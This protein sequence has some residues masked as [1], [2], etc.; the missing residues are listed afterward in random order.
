MT[1]ANGMKCLVVLAI[2]LFLLTFPLRS[3]ACSLAGCSGDGE[4]MGRDFVVLVT[5]QGRPLP[6][7]S[8]WVTRFP[9][10]D[11]KLFLGATGTDGTTRITHAL[12]GEYWLH[13]DL[14]G[15]GAGGGCFHVSSRPSKKARQIVSYAWGDLAPATN[16][17]AGR[18]IDPQPGEGA[19]LLRNVLNHVVEPISGARLKLQNALTAEVYTTISN[20]DGGFSFGSIPNGTYV[21]HVEGGM[22]PG[23]RGYNPT[24]LLI[25]VSD[26]ATRNMLLL[27]R[28][29]GGGGECGGPSLFLE[30]RTTPN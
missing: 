14:L 6:G 29:S 21:L 24:D 26:T 15:I 10:D 9:G 27:W 7:V 17:M 20:P 22:T 28:T 23:G 30:L 19:T 18:L 25:G 11:S 12:R 1:E 13:T 5:H 2:L 3:P 4:E 8:V 16:E